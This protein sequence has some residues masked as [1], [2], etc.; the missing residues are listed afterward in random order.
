MLKSPSQSQK[1]SEFLQAFQRKQES[2]HCT[3]FDCEC[4]VFKDG[5]LALHECPRMKAGID[6]NKN[7][8]NGRFIRGHEFD[9]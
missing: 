8:V 3:R 7:G 2:C 6:R 4:V 9:D 1:R 5:C